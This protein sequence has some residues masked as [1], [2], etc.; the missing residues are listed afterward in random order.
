MVSGGRSHSIHA[1][2]TGLPASPGVA[3]G[4][5]ATTPASASAA[6]TA[7]RPVILVRSETSPED[8]PGMAWAAG[9]LTSR[10]GL[11]SHAAVVARGWGIPAVVGAEAVKVSDQEVEIGGQVLKVGETI[12]IDGGTGEVFAGVVEGSTTVAPEVATLLAWASELGIAINGAAAEVASV[13]ERDTAATAD[14]VVRALVVKGSTMLDGLAAAL[15]ASAE[16]L[17]PLLDL[18]VVDGLVEANDDAFRLTRGGKTR[19][20]AQLAADQQRWGIGRAEE[21][22]DAFL[23][24]DPRVKE[25][26]TAW[27]LREVGGAQAI[28]DHTD[29]AYDAGVLGRLAGVHR[30]ATEWMSSLSH[31]PPGLRVYLLRLERA[32][33]SARGGDGRFIASPRVDSYHGVW[34]ELHEELILLAGRNRADEAAAGRA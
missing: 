26:V 17:R 27:Q 16:H 23:V 10:G 5:I 21:A 14:D 30:D 29:G 11:A 31:P 34:F 33:A 9:V 25:V 15:L 28:N 8:V 2:A 6:G 19:G 3:S 18:L 13:S 24:I 1:L 22:L 20:Q 4:E 12:T 32:L 7:G